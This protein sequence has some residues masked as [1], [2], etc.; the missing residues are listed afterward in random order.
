MREIGRIIATGGLW[1]GYTLLAIALVW[2][3]VASGIPYMFLVALGILGVLTLGAG[4][5]TA[6]VWRGV[7]AAPQVKPIPQKAKRD[8]NARLARLIEQLDDEEMIELE[9]LLQRGEEDAFLR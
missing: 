3:A 7:A 6:R 2:M 4:V 1:V 9:A 5:A 8:L